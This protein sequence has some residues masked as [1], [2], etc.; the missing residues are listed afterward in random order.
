MASGKNHCEPL[1]TLMNNNTGNVQNSVVKNQVRFDRKFNGQVG[2]LCFRKEAFTK[3]VIII[4]IACI[5]IVFWQ[6]ARRFLQPSPHYIYRLKNIIG[7][8]VISA[9]LVLLKSRKSKQQSNIFG[10]TPI[11][12]D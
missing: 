7:N 5:F 12:V 9:V 6:P 10:I 8:L 11:C 3:K 2:K 1:V 4:I